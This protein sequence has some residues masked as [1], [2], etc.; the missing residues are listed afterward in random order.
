MGAIIGQ[1][2]QRRLKGLFSAKTDHEGRSHRLFASRRPYDRKPAANAWIV[3]REAEP[4]R[5]GGLEH[6]DDPP[7]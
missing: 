6:K 7:V 3:N 5:P 2:S 4:K 1:N